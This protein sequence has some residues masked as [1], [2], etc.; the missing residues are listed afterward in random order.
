MCA[1]AAVL[2]LAFLALWSAAAYVSLEE[3]SED[4]SSGT[5]PDKLIPSYHESA[6]T[7]N[8]FLLINL[9][10][11]QSIPALLLSWFFV[12]SLLPQFIY[13]ICLP[14]SIVQA[15][16]I[17]YV[18]YQVGYL[19]VERGGELFIIF[20][21]LCRVCSD[22]VALRLRVEIVIGFPVPYTSWAPNHIRL[23]VIG[24]SLFCELEV[25]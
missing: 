7:R 11:T 2:L 3:I 15:A 17:A 24:S 5:R 1:H 23:W 18:K 9:W 16:M 14:I 20:S 21:V 8:Q 25:S 22:R 6:Y 19:P 4:Y 13:L 12:T 10:L